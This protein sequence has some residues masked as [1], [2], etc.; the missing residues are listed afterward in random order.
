LKGDLIYSATF[1]LGLYQ[2]TYPDNGS[3]L[4]EL[5]F[6]NF[7]DRSVDHAEYGLVQPDHFHP[8]LIIGCTM[9]VL[10]SKSYLNVKGLSLAIFLCFVVSFVMFCVV[11]LLLFVFMLTL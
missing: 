9:P 3:N 6:S 7:A 4:L 1:F 5:A 11:L 2:H 10:F 8:P